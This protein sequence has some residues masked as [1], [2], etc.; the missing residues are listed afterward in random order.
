MNNVNELK[1]IAKLNA[2]SP[3]CNTCENK[4]VT[5]DYKQYLVSFSRLI[6][7]NSMVWV[8]PKEVF[9][10]LKGALSHLLLWKLG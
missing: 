9:P 8:A 5:T 7:A 2:L 10:P 4:L 1:L 3:S 6:W